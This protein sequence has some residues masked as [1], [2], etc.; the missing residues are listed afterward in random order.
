MKIFVSTDSTQQKKTV[1]QNRCITSRAY[2]YLETAI[3]A[4]TLKKIDLLFFKF[5]ITFYAVAFKCYV[6]SNKSMTSVVCVFIF[7]Y[8]KFNLQRRSTS[9]YCEFRSGKVKLFNSWQRCVNYIAIQFRF[10]LLTLLLIDQF[11]Q[12]MQLIMQLMQL[13]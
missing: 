6:S 9:N 12:C 2:F 11:A 4:G 13:L 5:E 7:H 8:F 10:D 3:W 1:P